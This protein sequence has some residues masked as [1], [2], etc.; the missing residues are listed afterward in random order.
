MNGITLGDFPY[1]VGLA[2]K[3]WKCIIFQTSHYMLFWLYHVL[4]KRC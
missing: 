4:A 1:L 2:L 3:V